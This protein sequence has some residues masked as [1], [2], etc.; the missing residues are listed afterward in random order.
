MK[1][2]HATQDPRDFKIIRGSSQSATQMPLLK[3]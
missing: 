2:D 1:I 3:T